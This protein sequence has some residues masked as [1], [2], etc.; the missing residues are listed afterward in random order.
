MACGSEWR[1][2]CVLLMIGRDGGGREPLH[3]GADIEVESS[4]TMCL[5]PVDAV[6]IYHT[7]GGLKLAHAFS[8]GSRGESFLIF[9]S[10]WLLLTILGSSLWQLKSNFCFHQNVVDFPC[11]CVFSVSL[12]L[13]GHKSLD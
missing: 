12:L 4:M 11:V 6:R 7:L 2:K 3:R 9:S 5:F 10:F 1:G 13:Q 8:K